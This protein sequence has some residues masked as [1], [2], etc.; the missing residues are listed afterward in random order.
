MEF[1]KTGKPTGK[2]L[3]DLSGF[4]RF[5][6]ALKD[7]YALYVNINAFTRG[8]GFVGIMDAVTKEF[9]ALFGVKVQLRLQRTNHCKSP[10]EG[11][12]AHR[13]KEKCGGNDLRPSI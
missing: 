2:T 7:P 6:G 9:A 8:G 1:K 3:V 11:Y 10:R 13:C 4:G 12:G 5:Y